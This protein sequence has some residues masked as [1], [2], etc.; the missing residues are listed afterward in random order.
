[1]NL[2]LHPEAGTHLQRKGWSHSQHRR[3]N[4]PSCIREPD[5]LQHGLP[6]KGGGHHQMDC[7]T[8]ASPN[9]DTD[10]L[11]EYNSS[12]AHRRISDPSKTSRPLIPQKSVFDSRLKLTGENT[13]RRE[14]AQ[15]ESA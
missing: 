3:Y 11:H 8:S 4:P 14:R 15:Q 9:P 7:Q 10:W 12:M 1:M 13:L 5:C 2:K 6:K